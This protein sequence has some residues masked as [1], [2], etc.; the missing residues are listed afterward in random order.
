MVIWNVK[1]EVKSYGFCNNE[2]V[3]IVSVNLSFELIL[4][5]GYWDFLGY[6]LNL[7]LKGYCFSVIKI[8]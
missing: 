3:K 8:Y 7:F 1:F 2:S 6:G 4:I 5:E